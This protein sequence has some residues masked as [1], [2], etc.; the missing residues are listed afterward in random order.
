MKSGQKYTYSVDANEFFIKFV[1][2]MRGKSPVFYQ[3]MKMGTPV[4]S[5][6]CKN[7]TVKYDTSAKKFRFIFNPTFWDNMTDNQRQAELCHLCEHVLQKHFEFFQNSDDYNSEQIN[8]ACDYTVNRELIEK[9]GIPK[10]L[11][12]SLNKVGIEELNL[13]QKDSLVLHGLSC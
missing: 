3:M 12:K 11:L 5:K 13:N 1:D 2:T 6:E 8:K 4:F 9:Y 10:S 7:S